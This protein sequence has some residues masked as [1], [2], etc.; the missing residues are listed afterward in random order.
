M[1]ERSK[2]YPGAKKVSE[3]LRYNNLT[4]DADMIVETREGTSCR[5]IK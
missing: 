2:T 5:I 3:D 1:A 4:R